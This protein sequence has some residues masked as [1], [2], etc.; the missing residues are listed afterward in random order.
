M[1][2]APVNAQSCFLLTVQ[3]FS[4]FSCKEYNQFVFIIDH[5]VMSMCK[6][7][8][9]VVGRWCLLWSVCSLGKTLLTFALLNFVLQGQTCLLLQVSLDLLLLHFN[10]LWWEHFRLVL[11]GLV[12]LLEPFSFS[13]F[14]ING[15]GINL[16]YC[17][18][19]SFALEMNLGHSIVFE[20]APKYCISDSFVDY[21]GYT[22]SSKGFLPTA[23]DIM[24]IWIKFAYSH[25]SSSWFLKC[26]C[27][28]LPSP[29]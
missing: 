3:S 22:I 23:V 29:V 7:V 28:L 1:I 18:I 21:V 4:M 20:I 15:W 9:C 12:D 11:E 8:S 6:V 16:D 25:P 24:V 17:N 19:E 14:G 13:F 10:P 27:S 26:W 2:W 5:L